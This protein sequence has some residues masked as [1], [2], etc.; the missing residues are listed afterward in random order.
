MIVAAAQEAKPVQRD[1]GHDHA[2]A[3]DGRS[4]AVHPARG[5]GGE[6]TPIAMFERQ[7]EFAAIVAVEQRRAPLIPGACDGKTIVAVNDT[8]FFAR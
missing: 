1:R 5:R 8:R 7:H 3:Q 4:G 2:R 6:I